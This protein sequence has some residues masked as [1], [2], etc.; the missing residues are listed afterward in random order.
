MLTLPIQKRWFDMILSGEKK[1]EYRDIKEYYE[2]R[3][4]NLF[5]AITIY[6][7]SI[8]SDRSK[9]E[10]LQGEAVPEEIRKDSIQEIIFRN[11]YSK[12]S[13][14]IKARCKLRIG[15]GRPEWG[16]LPD[17][18]YYILEILDK[19][20]LAADKNVLHKAGDSYGPDIK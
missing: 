12:D 17:K 20:E 9:Y 4:Q 3:F 15:K 7:S 1:E 19:E 6:P 16:A 14:A 8:F 18:Q 10:L 13:K 2:T 11:G 5:G